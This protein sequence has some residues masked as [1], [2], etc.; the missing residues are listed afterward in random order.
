MVCGCRRTLNLGIALVSRMSRETCTKTDRP[1]PLIHQNVNDEAGL[2]YRPLA[3][4]LGVECVEVLVDERVLA[5]YTQA[6]FV[7]QKVLE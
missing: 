2:L 7:K 3:N 5:H 6:R 1:R 4:T